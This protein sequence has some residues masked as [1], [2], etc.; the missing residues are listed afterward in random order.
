M[1]NGPV[2]PR[3][4]G[5]SVFKVVSFSCTTLKGFDTTVKQSDLRPTGMTGLGE[6]CSTANQNGLSGPEEEEWLDDLGAEHDETGSFFNIYTKGFEWFL[7]LIAQNKLQNKD[8]IVFM[9]YA[10]SADWRTGRSRLTIDRVA[11]ILDQSRTALYPSIRRLKKQFLIVP[12]KDRRTG[13]GLI[14]VSPVFFKAGSPKV[15]GYMLR[16]Y[17]DAIKKNGGS[18]DDFRTSFPAGR[19]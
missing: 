4:L 19:F 5:A 15:K 11:K 3:D 8:L 18:L 16:T 7:R 1:Q 10:A 13:E 12:I 17:F 9:V 2:V 6:N 14:I